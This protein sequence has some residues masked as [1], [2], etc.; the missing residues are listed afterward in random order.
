MAGVF[1]PSALLAINLKAEQAWSGGRAATDLIPEAEAARVQLRNQTARFRELDNPEK[2][3]SVVVNWVKSCDIVDEACETNCDLDGPEIDSDNKTYT[4]DLCR[5]TDFSVDAT[6]LRTNQFDLQEV[7][8]EAQAR[9][10][11]T[12]DEYWAKQVLL[13]YKAF[14]GV[15]I[16]DDRPYNYNAVTNQTE[17]PLTAG[18]SAAAGLVQTAILNRMRDNFIIED[19]TNFIKFMDAQF[20]AGNLNGQGDAARLRAYNINFD[21]YNFAAAALSENAFMVNRSSV[22]MKTRNLNP[23]VPTVLGGSIQQTLYRVNSIALAEF[24][25]QYDVYYTLKCTTV[26]GKAHYVHVFRFETNG[27][28][29]LNPEACPVT[30]NAVS[31]EPT[32]VIA[33]KYV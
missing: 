18:V 13:K 20:N 8:A 11:K 4:Y 9:A 22:A 3:N 26:G 10:I 16:A 14:A 2:D 7:V 33:I 19:G 17:I 5:K 31:Y 30:V 25:I 1:T 32:G 21:M 29:W 12:L 28:I 27:G 15:N 24:G 6:K 23:A